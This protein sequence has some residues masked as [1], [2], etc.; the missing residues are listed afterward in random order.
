MVVFQNCNQNGYSIRLNTDELAK[1]IA[2]YAITCAEQYDA[3]FPNTR[4]YHDIVAFGFMSLSLD[5]YRFVEY[6]INKTLL[7]S[8]DHACI[9]QSDVDINC[10]WDIAKRIINDKTKLLSTLHLD[11]ESKVGRDEE[12]LKYQRNLESSIEEIIERCRSEFQHN[13]DT[14]LRAAILAAILNQ[15]DCPLFSNALFNSSL[16]NVHD[17]YDESLTYYVNNNTNGF[18][19]INDEPITNPIKE[20]KEV[21]GKLI[22]A[23][24]RVKDLQTQL[25]ELEGNIESSQKVDECYLEDGKF[26]FH[27]QHFRLLPN[28]KQ[29][30]LAETYVPHENLPESIDL[31]KFFNDIKNQGEQGS[32]LAHA[33]T[34]VFEYI[35]KRSSQ[36]EFDL[37]EA[38]LYYNARMMDGNDDVSVNTD[39][40]SRYKPAMDSL[41]KYGIALERLCPYHEDVYTQKP[42][43]EAYKDASTRKLITAKNVNRTI[44]DVKS[45]LADGFPVAVSFSLMQSFFDATDG[46]IPMPT[47]DEISNDEADNVHS[48]HAMV[49]VGYSDKLQ[50]FVLRNSWGKEWGDEGYCYVPYEY[51]EKESLCDFCCIITEV[52]QLTLP[53]LDVVPPLYVDDSDSRIRHLLT[54]VALKYSLSEVSLYQKLRSDLIQYLEQEKKILLDVNKKNEFIAYTEDIT[55][56]E[57]T[58]LEGEKKKIEGQLEER[59]ERFDKDKIHFYIAL[60][61]SFVGWI[62][63]F[64]G[65]SHLCHILNEEWHL[66]LWLLIVGMA[67]V[68][69]IFAIRAY[70][71]FKSWKCDRDQFLRDI[72]KVSKQIKQKRLYEEK[73]KIYT[74]TTWSLIRALEKVESKISKMY[75]N[76]IS[77]INNL[78]V[79]YNESKQ[80]VSSQNQTDDL[81][82]PTFSLIDF[83]A[84]DEYYDENIKGILDTDI[85]FCEEIDNYKIDPSYLKT[86]KDKLLSDIITKVLSLPSLRNF[87]ISEHVTNPSEKSIG[88]KVTR[89]EL[90]KA[91]GMSD[92]FLHVGS[93]EQGVI[94]PSCTIFAP[95]LISYQ[96]ELMTKF[97]FCDANFVE[98]SLQYDMIMVQNI[99]L[100]YSESVVLSSTR[101]KS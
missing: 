6:L 31:K 72:N 56:E 53:R 16:T 83:S 28:V 23:Q 93:C 39:A 85:D 100:N 13:T 77:L 14:T 82:I 60:A 34:S 17:L 2:T 81:H 26:V 84:L 79:W 21:T 36:K 40:G 3:L 41:S 99:T 47:D 45:A 27:G 9:N 49:I 29:E 54:S 18:Y 30:P 52:D 59:T 88:L 46:Y 42:S 89:D 43:E 92:V 87:N 90:R 97:E 7:G 76:I 67:I 5:K 68:L 80:F 25:F 61:L 44:A 101:T 73:F 74:N 86:Y 19:T 57:I 10:A 51:V 98:S 94:T 11:I 66:P 62:A 75:I 37:S 58:N 20:L 38:F 95:S 78:R 24:T 71:M 32:C 35:L 96:N 50:H 70:K 48:H 55:K 8:I 63:I 22:N 33:V 4:Q 91:F 1:V 65:I 15:T 69:G 12:I 64:F